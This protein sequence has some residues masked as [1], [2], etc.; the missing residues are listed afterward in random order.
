MPSVTPFG[1]KR[2]VSLVGQ[3]LIGWMF[4]SCGLCVGSNGDANGGFGA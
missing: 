2:A 3:P 4:G 1:L